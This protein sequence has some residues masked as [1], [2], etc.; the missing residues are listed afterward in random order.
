[1]Y[2]SLLRS[3]LDYA[4][5]TSISCNKDVIKRYEILQN[6]ALRI[7]FKRFIMDHVRVEDLSKWAG[8]TSVEDRHK[9]LL[10]RYYERTIM[11]DNPLLKKLFEN[12]K[13]I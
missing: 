11:S 10:L 9:E 5:V 1:M 7:V 3:V 13:K 8:V 6:D 12:Y 4:C 2:K